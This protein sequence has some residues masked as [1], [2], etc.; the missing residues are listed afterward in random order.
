MTTRRDVAYG[1]PSGSDVK[2]YRQL[3]YGGEIFACRALAVGDSVILEYEVE[4]QALAKQK[5]DV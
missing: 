3:P 1:R 5:S 2:F 4:V